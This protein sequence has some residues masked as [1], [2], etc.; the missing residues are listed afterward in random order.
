MLLVRILLTVSLCLFATTSVDLRADELA[1]ALER[2][3]ENRP[4]LE[5]ALAALEGAERGGLEFL[6]RHMPQRDLESLDADFLV[7]N[8]RVA[9]EVRGKVPWGKTVPKDVF[10]ND[11]LPYASANERRD[12]WRKDFAAR[13]QPVVA[14]CKTA[15]EAAQRLNE[16]VFGIVGVKY[17][18]KRKKADQSPYE[19]MESGL[20][21]CTGL[22]I[23][24]V[25]ACRAVGVPARLAGIASWVNKRGNHTWVEVWHDGWHFTGAAEPSRHGLDRTW[26]QHDASLAKR[27]ERR[28]A[29]WAT[30]FRK[31]KDRFP[32]VWAPHLQYVR[33]VNVTDRYTGKK[34]PKDAA[35]K[36]ARLLVRV[37]DGKGGPRV[38][39]TI[40]VVEVGGKAKDDAR[41]WRGKSRDESAD[42]NDI[43][44]FGLPRAAR[45]EIRVALGKRRARKEVEIDAAE[46]SVTIVLP[47]EKSA[48]GATK[49]KR[50]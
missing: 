9:Y 33:A 19:S 44:A 41:T 14:D 3:G 28:H 50:L 42:T 4:E 29:I 23:L 15:G 39:A 6:I 11:V 40:E 24:L 26:F 7:E 13:F 25:D 18:T 46:R 16:K 12:R 8:V 35:G 38:A 1:S 30:S 5:K 31:T 32:M 47:K 20:A 49:R 22:S 21:S 2:A 43:L 27:D 34:E 36:A 17:S 10:L 37:V 48:P 45:Y